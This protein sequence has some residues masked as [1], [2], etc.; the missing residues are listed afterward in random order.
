MPT[1]STT[2]TRI[3]HVFHQYLEVRAE[4]VGSGPEGYVDI[5]EVKRPDNT[6]IHNLTAMEKY[7]IT[8]ALLAKLQKEKEEYDA[9]V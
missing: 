3:V 8:T 9:T 2:V 1:P 7:D 6:V 4:L 5:L